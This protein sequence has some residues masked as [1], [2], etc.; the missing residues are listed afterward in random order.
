MNMLVFLQMKIPVFLWMNMLAHIRTLYT[1]QQLILCTACETR[2]WIL[3]FMCNVAAIA[4]DKSFSWKHRWRWNFYHGQWSCFNSIDQ[5]SLPLSFEWCIISNQNVNLD[6]EDATK[7]VIMDGKF[8]QDSGHYQ[9]LV[10][11]AMP[12]CAAMSNST[13]PPTFCIYYVLLT[14]HVL[15]PDSH[16]NS[17][18]L[19]SWTLLV[20][21]LLV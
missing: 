1:C 15:I 10:A 6:H 7:F 11:D 21:T 9:M 5:T 13:T 8:L 12:L 16:L 20:W 2:T 19:N 3:T 17:Y 4:G 18:C 14:S